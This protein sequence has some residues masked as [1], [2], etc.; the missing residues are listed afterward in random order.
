MLATPR[1]SFPT[2]PEKVLAL[3]NRVAGHPQQSHAHNGKRSDCRISIA[4]P[5]HIAHSR[6]FVI[7]RFSDACRKCITQTPSRRRPITNR[8]R[9][10]CGNRSP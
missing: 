7:E 9:D 5:R 1:G 10:I 3:Q 2:Q 4:P 8:C 6:D